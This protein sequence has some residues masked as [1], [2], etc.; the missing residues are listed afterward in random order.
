M[1]REYFIH[2]TFEDHDGEPADIEPD[3]WPCDNL[4]DAV[5]DLY[6]TRTAHVDGVAWQ[7]AQYITPTRSLVI[8]VCN[9]REFRT[10]MQE[11]RL[12]SITDITAASAARLAHL[13]NV[14]L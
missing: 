12:L 6:R 14:R 7:D 3:C 8:T 10:G 2:Q 13:L 1:N 9:G 4:H 11:T 5:K